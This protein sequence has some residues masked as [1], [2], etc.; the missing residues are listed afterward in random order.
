MGNMNAF[1]E[2]YKDSCRNDVEYKKE[3]VRLLWEI[4]QGLNQLVE[5]FGARNF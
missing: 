4:E 1:E 5:H 3:L 2:W